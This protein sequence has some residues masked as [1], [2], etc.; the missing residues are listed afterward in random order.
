MRKVLFY[1]I[2]FIFSGLSFV[3]CGGSKTVKKD[4]SENKPEKK[5]NISNKAQKT[6]IDNNEEDNNET[7]KSKEELINEFNTI[8]SKYALDK[9]SNT[10]S[11]S[12]YISE[13]DNVTHDYSLIP[14]VG[15]NKGTFYLNLGKFQE[16]YNYLMKT[17]KK[18]GYLPALINLSYVAYRLNRLNEVLPLLD[19]AAKK[20]IKDK[21]LKEELLSN[22]SFILILQKKYDKAL[23][24]IREILSFKPH[25]ILAYRNLG[26]L[27]TNSKKYSLAEKVIDLSISYTKDKKE[28][29]ELYVVKARYY[30]AKVESVKMIAAY[31]KAISLNPTNIDANYALALLY[32]KYGAGDKAVKYLNTLVV[33][34]PDNILFKNLYAIALRMDNKFDKS[35]SVYNELLKSES[36]YAD[37]Y[38]NR[39]LLLQKYLEKPQEAIK[40]YKKYKSLGGKLDVTKRIEICEQMIKDIEQ[41]KAEEEAD[42]NN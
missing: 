16:A 33:N 15:F 8:M 10:L 37:A 27:Y 19:S 2:I 14:E 3:S 18:S 28:Q 24:W 25:S 17:Y 13:M 39:A 41:M 4:N 20:E 35:L 26:I 7:S 32:M 6:I 34:Y 22:Y 29:A 42:G 5:E 21:K 1:L 40:D 31:K 23:S 36:S 38:F 30:K 9:K 12:K 11:L